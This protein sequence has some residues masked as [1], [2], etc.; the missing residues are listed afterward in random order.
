MSFAYMP[1]YTG[2]YLRDTRH[3][4]PQRHGI[5]LLLLMHCWDQ[6]GPLPLEE[7]ECAG[8][9]NCRSS[10]EIDGLRYVLQRYFVRMEDGLYNKRMADEIAK[11]ETKSMAYRDAGRKSAEARL[12]R[13]EVR[14]TSE[15]RLN[16]GSTTVEQR[17]NQPHTVVGNPSPNPNTKPT[18][19]QTPPPTPSQPLTD[20]VL[21][22][23]TGEPNVC[24]CDSQKTEN[25]KP[26]RKLN[27]SA[28]FHE[29]WEAWPASPRKVAKAK[30][31]E[32]WR[33]HHL[34]DN[35]DLIVAHVTAMKATR[36]WSDGFEPA[37][38]TYL[39]QRRWEDGVQP[40]NRA[41]PRRLTVVEQNKA[42]V[43][44]WLAQSQA[45]EGTSR[46]IN[47]VGEGQG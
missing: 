14:A 42:A 32:R 33:A 12:K 34:D 2:D 23:D 37:P 15:Q 25:R 19:N 11:A 24:E 10:D 46:R 16:H 44:E 1:M 6:K 35:A 45:I 9:A 18:P 22:T 26:P 3:L 21:N 43:Q 27:G 17:L 38:M 31:L 29:F 20:L 36:Q 39:N 5:Y 47:D 13:S 41:P 30:C 40:D 7:Y 28:R 4:S 8:I